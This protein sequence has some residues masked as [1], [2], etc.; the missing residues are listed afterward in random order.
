MTLPRKASNNYGALPP[1]RKFSKPAPKL[2]FPSP[3]PMPP[4][5]DYCNPYATM[6]PCCSV[7]DCYECLTQAQQ[8]IYGAHSIYGTTTA[9]TTCYGCAGMTDCSQTLGR[10]PS[11]SL[12]SGIYNTKFGMSKK[13][14][15]Q[16]DYSCSW[17]D[18]NRVMGRQY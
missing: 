1:Q 15:L 7:S 13:G 18:L 6:P 4:T 11:S 10:R 2:E 16:I 12:Y 14:L 5:Y 17:N 8:Q 9:P 3:P